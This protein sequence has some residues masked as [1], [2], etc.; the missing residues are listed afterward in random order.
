MNTVRLST[1]SLTIAIAVMTLGY[2][3]P[4][5]A[6][7]PD[8]GGGHEHGG[9]G[10]GRGIIQNCQ[11]VFGLTSRTSGTGSCN[12]S[13]S[14][15]NKDTTDSTPPSFTYVLQGDCETDTMLVVPVFGGLL[16]NGFTLTALTVA[17]SDWSGPA[18]VTNEGYRAVIQDLTI[19]IDTPAASGCTGTLKA[20]ILYSI[21]S[22]TVRPEAPHPPAVRLLAQRNIIKSETGG[23]ETGGS[24]TGSLCRGIEATRTVNA[25]GFIDRFIR[26]NRN[27]IWPSSYAETGILVRGFGPSDATGSEITASNNNVSQGVGD[28]TTAMQIGPA[29]TDIVSLEKNLL[30]AGPD[31]AGLAIFGFGEGFIPAGGVPLQIKAVRNSITGG[32][33]GIVVDE[34]VAASDVTGNSLVGDDTADSIAVCDDS[35][36]PLDRR[37]KSTGYHDAL[38]GTFVDGTV[39]SSL[40]PAN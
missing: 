34:T 39:C 40:S 27:E 4:S 23:S 37:N 5:F 12:C 17:A 15:T 14:V 3:N 9:G 31:G 30:A 26:V 8:D 7:P 32:M 13:F 16:G 2:A 10:G 25:T 33:F 21:N 29:S 20:G 28:A 24:E 19:N 18:V 22:G 1:L 38:L 6:N 11:Q 35:A 36:N